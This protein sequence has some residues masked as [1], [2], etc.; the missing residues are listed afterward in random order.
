[1][2][3]EYTNELYPIEISEVIT[4]YKKRTVCKFCKSSDLSHYLNE[5]FTICNNCGKHTI[6]D[7]RFHFLEYI[8]DFK[9]LHYTE[10][11]RLIQEAYTNCYGLYDEQNKQE[12]K[13]YHYLGL[14]V[15]ETQK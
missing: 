3:E 1:M 13:I 2:L 15:A 6:Y 11:K 10:K 7:H 9:S 14:L 12:G 4:S 8:K 5:I